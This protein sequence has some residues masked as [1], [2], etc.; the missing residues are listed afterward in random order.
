VRYLM[1][2]KGDTTLGLR[3]GVKGGGCYRSLLRA[4]PGAGSTRQRPDYEQ[5]G[6]ASSSTRRARSFCRTPTLDFSIKNI[7]EGG[8]I[9]Q[10]PNAGRNLR[11]RNVVYTQVRA[12]ESCESRVESDWLL[13]STLDARL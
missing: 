6:I 5:E 9:F 8:W 2:K 11:L 7:L 1:Q 4:E 3:V 10:N 13:L 12:I